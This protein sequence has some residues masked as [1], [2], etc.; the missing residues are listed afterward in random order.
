MNRFFDWSLDTDRLSFGA[1]GVRLTF[2]R[3]IP[4]YL[5]VG[6]IV[7]CVCIGVWAYR[8]VAGPNAFRWLLLLC[9]AAARVSAHCAFRGTITRAE[10]R[11]H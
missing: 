4:M 2:E 3:S 1:E 5:W 10:H 6:I 11:E 8:R 9:R 7:G